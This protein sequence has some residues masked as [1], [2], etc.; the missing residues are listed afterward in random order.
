MARLPRTGEMRDSVRI[1]RRV[2]GNIAPG[3]KEGAWAELIP[4]Q[5]A[6]LMP[7]RGGEDMQAERLTGVIFYELELRFSQANLGIVAADRAVN[8]RTGQTYNIRHA[9][10]D[11]ERKNRRLVMQVSLGDASG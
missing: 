6:S 11:P 5:P 8:A 2:T 4:A 9:P 1:E 10:I 7:L 3:V